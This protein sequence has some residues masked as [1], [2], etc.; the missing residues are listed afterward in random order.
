MDGHFKNE[1]DHK[2]VDVQKDNDPENIIFD[3]K[4]Q[5]FHA[6]MSLWS[7]VKSRLEGTVVVVHHYSQC[8]QKLCFMMV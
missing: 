4:T 7:Y 8:S 2:F 5:D 3:I 6:P 1:G